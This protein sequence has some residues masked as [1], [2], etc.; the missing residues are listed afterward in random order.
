MAS[1]ATRAQRHSP[2]GSRSTGCAL[3]STTANRPAPRSL[4]YTLR[5]ATSLTGAEDSLAHGQLHWRRGGSRHRRGAPREPE[6]S[7]APQPLP[8]QHQ[9]Q[10][11]RRNCRDPQQRAGVPTRK[12]LTLLTVH[13][14]AGCEPSIA[15]WRCARRASSESPVADCQAPTARKVGPSRERGRL[16]APRRTGGADSGATEAAPP[17]SPLNHTAT[18]ARGRGERRGQGGGKCD[19]GCGECGRG[20]EGARAT[21]ARSCGEPW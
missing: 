6:C 19:G 12:L 17:T 15:D 16:A 11:L 14:T 9:G 7:H 18:A 21:A 20:S 8:Q 10:G 3:Y 5:Y 4:R 1:S 2:R 13:G